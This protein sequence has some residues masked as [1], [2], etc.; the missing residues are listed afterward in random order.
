MW[1]L[2]VQCSPLMVGRLWYSGQCFFNTE[3]VVKSAVHP[4]VASTTGPHATSPVVP[5]S[6]DTSY[7]SPIAAP[8]SSFISTVTRAFFWV[9]RPRDSRDTSS[10]DHSQDLGAAVVSLGWECPPRR[11]TLEMSKWK[12]SCRQLMA[13]RRGR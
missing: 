2:P 13:C 12:A 11:A 6:F 3:S 7:A 8:L 1:P 9:S 4:P 5:F 10:A